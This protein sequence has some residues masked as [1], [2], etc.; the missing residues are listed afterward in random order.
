MKNKLS[1]LNVGS[2]HLGGY[3]SKI[4][5]YTIKNQLLDGETWELFVNQFR[6]HSDTDKDW[7]GEFWG[8]MMRGGSL[9]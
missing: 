7:R 2:Y 5:D 8:K 9:T 1:L 4:V 3:P 6:I